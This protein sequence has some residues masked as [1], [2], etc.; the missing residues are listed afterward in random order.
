M[1]N[2]HTNFVKNRVLRVWGRYA[3]I[4]QD[5]KPVLFYLSGTE[6]FLRE[7]YCDYERIF[8]VWKVFVDNSENN[9]IIAK[10]QQYM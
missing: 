10:K 1:Q 2:D 6:N 3:N 9:R 4:Q 8:E 5:V 7:A